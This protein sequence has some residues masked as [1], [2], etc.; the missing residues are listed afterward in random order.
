MPPTT[1]PGQRW[2]ARDAAMGQRPPDPEPEHAG[3]HRAHQGL[4]GDRLTV[5]VCQTVAMTDSVP[6]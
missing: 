3:D 4:E 5:S 6:A 1:A 2:A